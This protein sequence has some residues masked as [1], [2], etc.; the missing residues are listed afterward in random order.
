[1][2]CPGHGAEPAAFGYPGTG[3]D[4]APAAFPRPGGTIGECASH[5]AVLAAIGPC[6]SKGSREQSLARELY[7]ELEPDWLLIA[8]RN[9]Y[10]WQTGAPPRTPARRC[11]GG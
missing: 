8:D 5:A 1:M 4:D 9:F 3:N 11:Y 6:V 2:G 10:N 7:P